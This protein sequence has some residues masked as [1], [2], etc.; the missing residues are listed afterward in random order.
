MRQDLELLDRHMARQAATKTGIYLYAVAS[1]SAALAVEGRAQPGP[2]HGPA[3]IGGGAVYSIR[4]GRL[5]AVVSDVPNGK[6]RPER[7]NLATHYAVLKQL[8][9]QGP[10]L[11]MTFGTIAENEE[12]IRRILR[13]HEHLLIEQLKRVEGKVE[14]GLRVFW[15]VTNIFGHF[16]NA[17]QEL[18]DL[19]DRLFRPGYEPS[20]QEKMALGRSFAQMLADKRMIHARTVIAALR[21]SCFE[22]KETPPQEDREVMDLAC[23]IA[24]NAQADFEQAVRQA[25]RPFD[26]TY[27]FDISGP[28][29]PQNFV[30][31]NLAESPANKP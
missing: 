29:P 23:F 1:P 25:A 6:L 10:V 13:S 16:A 27:T 31:L 28:F 24:K 5:A 8:M 26:D 14:M 20:A 22:I 19:R 4:Y 30:D 21:D 18:R 3:G 7:R 2:A 9:A 11:P 12:G 15:N 17:F